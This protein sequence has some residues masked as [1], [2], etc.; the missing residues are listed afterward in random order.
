MNF[1]VM[2]E[3]TEHFPFSRDETLALICA[4]GL[5]SRTGAILLRLH[6]S[7]SVLNV[8]RGMSVWWKAGSEVARDG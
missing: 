4:S 6:G 1:K 5:R 2:R 3:G 8:T 7:R